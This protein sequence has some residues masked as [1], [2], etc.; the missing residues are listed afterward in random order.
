LKITLYQDV[1]G[2]PMGSVEHK[3]FQDLYVQVYGPSYVRMWKRDHTSTL[4][5]LQFPP[6][7]LAHMA[8]TLRQQG[9]CTYHWRAPLEY[10]APEGIIIG[11]YCSNLTAWLLMNT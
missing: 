5:T 3:L 2:H 1:I 10:G 11:R 6:V 7:N 8:R 4:H 9:W